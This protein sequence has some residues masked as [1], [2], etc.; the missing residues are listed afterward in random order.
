MV[1]RVCLTASSEC[2]VQPPNAHQTYIVRVWPGACATECST[3]ACAAGHPAAA[4][5]HGPS[6]ASGAR[7]ERP[8]CGARLGF[9][10]EHK[11]KSRFS[12]SACQPGRNSLLQGGSKKGITQLLGCAG[13]HHDMRI[14]GK[15]HGGWLDPLPRAGRAFGLLRLGAPMACCI[16]ELADTRPLALSAVC[17]P[18]VLLSSKESQPFAQPSRQPHSAQAGVAAS[19]PAHD[20]PQQFRLDARPPGPGPA[21]APGRVC[22]TPEPGAAQLPV[23]V[24]ARAWLELAATRTGLQGP[25]RCHSASAEVCTWPAAATSKP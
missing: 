11:P 12:A 7:C 8:P 22:L 15:G 13:D 19:A 16:L 17:L 4:C 14:L 9:R 18:H 24:S 21:G 2:I 23:R 3:G 6:T 10:F 5:Y 1:S 20:Q 25:L